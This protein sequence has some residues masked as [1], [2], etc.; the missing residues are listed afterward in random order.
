MSRAGVDRSGPWCLREG[1]GPTWAPRSSS[2]CAVRSSSSSSLP[3]SER[4]GVAPDLDRVGLLIP[5]ERTVVVI[6]QAY[7]RFWI[8][9]SARSPA[10]TFCAAGE[11]RD[12]RRNTPPG[13]AVN[14]DAGSGGDARV[15]PAG[16]SRPERGRFHEPGGGARRIRE[17]RASWIVCSRSTAESVGDRIRLDRA[18][19]RVG[20]T[21]RGPIYAVRLFRGKPAK[22]RRCRPGSASRPHGWRRT[23]PED[24]QRRT[25]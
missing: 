16:S 12:G 8:A 24:S 5:P 23:R 13:G 22:G 10:C 15:L 1:K 17:T 19:E 21:G 20:W 2:T 18:R 3:C 11:P 4:D 14:R 9:N 6:L 7:A 25:R